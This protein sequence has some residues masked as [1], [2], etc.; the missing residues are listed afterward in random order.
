MSDVQSL[1][2]AAALARG[3]DPALALAVAAQESNYDQFALSPRGAVG[4]F[5][6]MPATAAGL[7]VDPY[8]LQGNIDGGVLYLSQLSR[9]YGGDVSLTLAAYNAGPGNVE[10]YG[11]VPPFP[12]TQSYVSRILGALGLSDG[13]A[14][15]GSGDSAAADSTTAAGL[16]PLAFGALGVA[17]AAVVWW[18][19]R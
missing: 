19:V 17:A 7:G 18:F 1:I 14:A 12:E 8:T 9:Q 13:A 15:D 3:V 16:S 6:L 5:Q 10:K 2:R 4:V 11:G